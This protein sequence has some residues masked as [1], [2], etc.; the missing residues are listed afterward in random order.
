[1]QV[2]NVQTG[3]DNGDASK[4]D[5]KSTKSDSAQTKNSDVKKMKYILQWTSAQNVPFVY[6]GVGQEGFTSRK[7]PFTN[8][9]VTP[10]K[11]YLSDITKFDV[12]A[13]S[14]PEVIRLQNKNLPQVRS[15]KQKYVF[16]SIESSHYY[17]ICSNSLDGFFNWTWTFRLDSEVRWGYM[18]IKD[19]NNNTIGPKKIMHWMKVEEMDRV[20]DEF[21]DKLRTKTKAAAWFVS[22]CF[23]K[24]GRMDL[25][26]HLKRELK[27]YDLELDIY[28]ACGTL[29]CS[30][31]KQDY[32]HKMLDKTYY[33]YLSFENSFSEDYVTEKLL[34]AL[35]N[36]VVPVVYGGAN[37]TR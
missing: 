14:G 16:A 15:E 32:C 22:N 20:N 25:A 6:M 26:I 11:N 24:S 37:Y 5:V 17:P 21:K 7:C 19:S 33:F 8:C 36:N 31:D 29:T 28:G 4:S 18:L 1:M 9:I 30:R 10:D 27:K 23:D 34:H 13:F 2:I 35:Q 3:T 12:I